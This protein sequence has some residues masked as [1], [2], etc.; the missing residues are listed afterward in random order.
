MACCDHDCFVLSELSFIVLSLGGGLSMLSSSL[1]V[2]LAMICDL[3]LLKILL[4]NF[5]LEMSSLRESC[6]RAS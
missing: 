6:Q 5:A 2:D 4:E 1:M 3:L